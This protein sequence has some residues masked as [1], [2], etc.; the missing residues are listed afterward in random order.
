MVVAKL[1][2]PVANIGD[3]VITQLPPIV[4]F[5]TN[6]NSIWSKA[7]VMPLTIRNCVLSYLIT[8]KF[9]QEITSITETFCYQ[10]FKQVA[11]GIYRWQICYLLLLISNPAM[12]V[13]PSS[14]QTP[15]TLSH[16]LT[17]VQTVHA[18]CNVSKA[19]LCINNALK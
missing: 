9:F 15:L 13:K 1:T 8:G 18:H 12:S 6:Y 17:A 5:M 16:W 11:N 7:L 3:S 14:I 19:Y 10:Q 2:Y 4:R